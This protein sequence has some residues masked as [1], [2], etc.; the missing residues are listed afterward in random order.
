MIAFGRRPRLDHC[1]EFLGILF[2]IGKTGLATET[3]FRPFM[4]YDHGFSHGAEFLAR[5]DTDFEWIFGSFS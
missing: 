5:D 4:I 2:E 3:D 1:D